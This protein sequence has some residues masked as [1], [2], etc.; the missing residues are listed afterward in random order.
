[1]KNSNSNNLVNFLLSFEV[2]QGDGFQCFVQKAMKSMTKDQ[3]I[4]S[5][6]IYT[7]T[8]N[9]PDLPTESDIKLSENLVEKLATHV[10]GGGYDFLVLLHEA[11][12]LWRPNYISGVK[13]IIRKLFSDFCSLIEDEVWMR[14]VV[15][16]VKFSEISKTVD[17]TNY[18]EAYKFATEW[19]ES[20]EYTQDVKH[21]W[22][23]W[24]WHCRH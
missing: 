9:Y 2:N 5:L 1:M 20:W 23:D 16:R 4:E 18:W 7:A 15:E 21:D 14:D 13:P 10:T 24:E 22:S 12:W 6:A 3:F 11:A 19:F 8:V 17:L